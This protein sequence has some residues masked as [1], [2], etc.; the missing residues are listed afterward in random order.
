MQFKIKVILVFCTQICLRLLNALWLFFY[1]SPTTYAWEG[2]KKFTQDPEFHKYLVSKQAY[3]EKGV[4]AF[5][6]ISDI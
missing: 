5:M 3:N 4:N 2:A 6:K 1:I